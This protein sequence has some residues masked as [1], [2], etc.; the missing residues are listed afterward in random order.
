M[1][2]FAWLAIRQAREALKQGRLEEAHRL[3]TQPAIRDHR[4]VGDLLA[5]LARGYV[6]HGERQ[7]QLDDAEG[8]GAIC[9]KPN[10]CRRRKKASIASAKP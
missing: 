6:E 5:Q 4:A 9:C 8:P 1:F 10:N 3:L 7:L 2:G